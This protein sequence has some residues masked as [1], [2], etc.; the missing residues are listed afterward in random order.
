MTSPS[1]VEERRARLLAIRWNLVGGRNFDLV[2]HADLGDPGTQQATLRHLDKNAVL[3]LVMAPSCGVCGPPSHVNHAINHETWR[4]HYEQDAPHVRFCG[5]AVLHQLQQNLFVEQPR[6][7]WL[8]HEPPWP[9]L[10]QPPGI[11]SFLRKFPILSKLRWRTTQYESQ[12]PDKQ[13]CKPDSPSC[14]RDNSP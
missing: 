2:I 10:C 7:A 1:F 13:G 3:V 14:T 9:T 5:Q 6:P 8:F 11:C 4:A 12:G